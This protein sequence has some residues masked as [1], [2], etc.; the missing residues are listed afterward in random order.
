MYCNF[1]NFICQIYIHI[2][3]YIYWQVEFFDLFYLKYFSENVNLIRQK[4]Y[5]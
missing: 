1:S 3:I 5:S 2:Y 4:L